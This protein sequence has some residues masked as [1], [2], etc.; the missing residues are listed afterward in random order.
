MNS[1]RYK[2]ITPR[3]ITLEWEKFN[4]LNMKVLFIGGT[5][6]IS[7]ACSRR[8]ISS[9]IELFHM[10]RGTAATNIPKGVQTLA[11]DIRNINEFI[12][13]MLATNDLNYALPKI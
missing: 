3:F 6:N 2:S 4:R 1:D 13:A 11:A 9:G 7:G 8:A 10:N 12:F 5:G